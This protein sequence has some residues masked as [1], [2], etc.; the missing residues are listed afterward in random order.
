MGIKLGHI[1]SLESRRGARAAVLAAA[2]LVCMSLAGASEALAASGRHVAL[3]VSTTGLPAGQPAD[4]LLAGP[5]LHRRLTSGET[6]LRLRPGRYVLTVSPVAIARS[7]RAVQAGATAYPTKRRVVVTLRAS[8]SRSVSVR[9]DAIVNP[10]VR[11]APQVLART[12]EPDAP[13]S[14][15][16]AVR[17]G[18][19]ALGTILTSGPTKSLPMGLV[20]KV[21]A[22]K[23]SGSTLRVSLAAV[24]VTE[25]V[26][27]LSFAGSLPLTPTVGAVSES[28]SAPPAEAARA[29][30]VPAHA[31][32][33][34]TPPKLVQLGAHLDGVELREAFLGTWPP[35][36]KLTIAVRTSESLG[37]A[38][39]AAG[40]NC[41]FDLHEL[42]PYTAAIPVG[43]IVIP[44][45]A[46][47]PLKA[48]VHINGTLQAGTVNVASTTVA[49]AAAGW[50][51]TA[52]SLKQ[53]GSNVWITGT[54]A[55]TGSVKLS[56]SIGVQAGIGIAKGANVHLEAGFGPEF[57]WSSGHECELLLDLGSLSAGVTVLDKTLDTPTFTPFQLHLWHGCA[58]SSTTPPGGKTPGG[59][60]I[61]PTTPTPTGRPLCEDS[62][63]GSAPIPLTGAT[64]LSDGGNATT[65]ALISGGSI[66]CWGDDDDGQLGNG[67]TTGLE[68]NPTPVKVAG[69]TTARQVASGYPNCAV[70]DS[71][72]ID[73]WGGGDLGDGTAEP[74]GTVSAPVTVSSIT[75]A[76]S[77]G[78][79][80]ING[81]STCASLANGT[82]DCWGS[83][84]TGN[85]GSGS[86]N[87]N[88]EDLTPTPV[89]GL[90]NVASVSSGGFFCALLTTGHIDCWG[91]NEF[92]QLGAGAGAGHELCGGITEK[93]CSTKP[94]EVQGIGNA[95]AVSVGQTS[96]CAL[97]ATRQ[98]ECW[99]Q[100][101]STFGRDDTPVPVPIEGLS[102]VLAVA[103]GWDADC[104]L[105][106][107]GNVDC[108]G[109]DYFGELGDNALS[110]SATPVAASVSNA[111]AIAAGY[112][113]NCAVLA[114]GAVDCWGGD[115]FGQL[116][117]GNGGAT[118]KGD[119]AT[120]V[121]VAEV[122][123]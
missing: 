92:G 21:T 88:E 78:S 58:P 116:G 110:E 15:V 73:C 104:A 72:R 27:E 77:V 8:V 98:V 93:Y 123:G 111:T 102:Q 30:A 35:Q 26:P 36:V 59:G 74:P 80:G 69:V 7:N 75:D 31:A 42:G 121:S 67:V 64:A 57:D 122:A 52:A 53:Q 60:T 61:P 101:A 9:Y 109:L 120:P 99:G 45:Y 28:G 41:D 96:A 94:L 37:I 46:T 2:V 43:P 112:G 90:N 85:L 51:E 38:V 16:I 65:C 62:G 44:V 33:S 113:Q 18:K 81:Q 40:V 95:I 84:Y 56:A 66:D 118:A 55:L 117:N 32:S 108:W 119:S 39:A 100:E 20:A 105:L 17:Y 3:I 19:P 5:R 63:C 25:A 89:A 106:A 97:L 23:Q 50:D 49:H 86:T 70:L 47:V 34:C 115:V 24:P 82:V 83:N 11:R 48:G 6:R 29:A 54:L 79:V 68:S 87:L 14:I 13:S 91:E 76:T 71:G 12:G 10:D 22:V 103:T 1:S 107:G 114:A 4:I